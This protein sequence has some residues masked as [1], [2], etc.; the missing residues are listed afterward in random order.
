M[1]DTLNIASAAERDGLPTKAELQRLTDA[2]K[3]VR[4]EGTRVLPG[5]IRAR[6]RD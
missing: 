4:I 6:H 1:V 2:L 3:A 5:I